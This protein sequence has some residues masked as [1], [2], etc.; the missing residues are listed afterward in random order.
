MVRRWRGG[1]TFCALV[2]AAVPGITPAPAQPVIDEFVSGAQVITKKDC[3]LL[4]VNNNNWTRYAG[5]FPVDKG[6]EPRIG[7]RPMNL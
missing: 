5:H 6:D 1:L 2:L 4:I 7:V 3:A